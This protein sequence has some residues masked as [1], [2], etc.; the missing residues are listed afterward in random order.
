MEV[1]CKADLITI[2]DFLKVTFNIN[3]QYYRTIVVRKIKKSKMNTS[4]IIR[5]ILKYYT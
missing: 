3:I 5:I 2:S 4:K 1:V